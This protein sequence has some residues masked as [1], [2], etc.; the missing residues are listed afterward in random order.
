MCRETGKEI[1]GQGDQAAAAGDGIYKSGQKDQRT[2]D[3]KGLH[4]IHEK[5]LDFYDL[6]DDCTTNPHGL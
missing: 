3:Q 4:I 6:P 5:N 1:G 2:E